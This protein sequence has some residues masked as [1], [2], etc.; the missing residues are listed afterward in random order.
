MVSVIQVLV[1]DYMIIIIIIIFYCYWE[2]P[3]SGRW[4]TSGREP[5][6][7][8]PQA[9]MR[10]LTSFLVSDEIISLSKL[11]A[12]DTVIHEH[13]CPFLHS[14]IPLDSTRLLQYCVLYFLA[15]LPPS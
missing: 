9:P 13:R 5:A 10:G 1:S 2:G 3:L 11:I 14:F 12:K 8:L 7:D 15:F 6:G 4:E